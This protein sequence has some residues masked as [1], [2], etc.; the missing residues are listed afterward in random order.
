MRNT[1]IYGLLTV[2]LVFVPP[3]LLA[4][5]SSGDTK[6]TESAKQDSID[7]VSISKMLQT[8][9][10]ILSDLD[11]VVKSGLDNADQAKELY[12]GVIERYTEIITIVGSKSKIAAEFD[13]E[14]KKY[15]DWAKDAAA[16]TNAVRRTRAAQYLEIADNFAKIK[17]SFI[18]EAAR[19][20]SII[21]ELKDEKEVAVDDFRIGQGH[22]VVEAYRKQLEV[23]KETNDS[24]NKELEKI[25]GGGVPIIIK[26]VEQ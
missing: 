26:P 3:S 16:S 20:V 7:L 9:A 5:Q 14:I 22:L 21:D 13:A 12:D 8:N 25:R 2:G 19:A 10:K 24:M 11:K 15:Q 6:Q 4:Q 17:V 1:L 23:F 18:S